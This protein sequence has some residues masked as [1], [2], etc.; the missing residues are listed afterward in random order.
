MICVQYE[1]GEEEHVHL[2]CA[3]RKGRQIKEGTTVLY[4]IFKGKSFCCLPH[5]HTCASGVKVL[6]VIYLG[7][8]WLACVIMCADKLADQNYIERK[9][10][11]QL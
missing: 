8:A 5:A 3:I 2:T 4:F 9:I 10:I 1:E 11:K 7:H 6:S